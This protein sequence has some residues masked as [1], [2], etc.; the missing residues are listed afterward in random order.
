MRRFLFILLVLL[1][2]Y[3]AGVYRYLPLMVL[4]IIEAVYFVLSFFLSLYFRRHLFIEALRHS[5]CAKKGERLVCGIQVVNN[6]KLPV[7]RF[8]IRLWYGYHFHKKK[9]RKKK[10][11][12]IYGGCDCGESVLNFEISGQYCGRMYLQMDHLY[13]YD[14]L[15][16]FSARGEIKENIE[17]AIFPQEKALSMDLSSL[18]YQETNQSQE[19]TAQQGADAHSEI[20]QLREYRME[21]SDRYIHWK[22]SARIG[23][24]VVKEYERETDFA[25]DLLLDVAG[26]DKAKAAEL[27]AFYELTSAIVLGLLKQSAVIRVHWYHAGQKCLVD[28]KVICEEQCRDMLLELYRTE[29]YADD[30]AQ[31]KAELETYFMAQGGAFR[32]GID[33]C[34]YWNE[35]LIFQFSCK[36]LEEQIIQGSYVI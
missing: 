31:E 9:M 7:S 35:T 16:L 1:T 27:D 8:G 14:Y 36:K 18:S 24:L 30:S 33:L 3:L 4:S 29:K 5:D 2:F 17:V 32:L 11:K 26:L 34:W 6:G 20:R 25:V 12:I 10:S 21:D 22:Q 28:T 15:S 23:K 19:L 13:T